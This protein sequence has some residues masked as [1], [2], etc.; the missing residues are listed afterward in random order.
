MFLPTKAT[1]RSLNVTHCNHGITSVFS[2]MEDVG[3]SK[4]LLGFSFKMPPFI[5]KSKI[6]S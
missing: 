3:Q 6:P 2:K 4:F 1:S 5:S